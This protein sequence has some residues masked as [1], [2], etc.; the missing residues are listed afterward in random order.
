[1]VNVSARLKVWIYQELM[2]ILSAKKRVVLRKVL[3]E[4]Q[5]MGELDSIEK[6]IWSATILCDNHRSQREFL[7]KELKLWEKRTAL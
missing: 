1:M 2:G 3:N 5:K 4:K 6:I 7:K